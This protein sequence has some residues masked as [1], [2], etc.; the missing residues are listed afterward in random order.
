MTSSN[1]S[2][3]LPEF[4]D[5]EDAAR[6][7][8]G[9]AFRTP[10]LE[11]PLLNEEAGRRI[12][13]KAECLQRT[14]SF[15]FRGAYNRISRMTAEERARGVIAYSSGNHAQGV[16]HAAQI[17][18]TKATIVMPKDAPEMKLAN[19]Q[20]YGAQVVTYDRFGEDREEI[21]GEIAQRTGAVL[22]RPY[23]D[24]YV[25]AGQGTCGLELSEQCLERGIQPDAVITC[26]GGGGLTAG[27]SLAVEA[28]LPGARLFTSEPEHYDDWRLSLEKGERVGITPDHVS[29]C[30]AIVTPMPGVM[31]FP[32]AGPRLAG[33]L[34]VTDSQVKCAMA[35][36]F[37]RLKIIIEPGGA[38]AL[39]AA[40]YAGLADDVK[41]VVVTA[42]GGNVDQAVFA[43][44]LADAMAL[45]APRA[46]Q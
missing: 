19:T 1:P 21:G 46:A 5:V 36:A 13:V 37:D 9:E 23:D 45:S 43:A 25:I 39:A 15:K 10:L 42:S 16:A 34:V 32:I 8:G 18:G 28:K 29:I 33:G 38:V 17:C 27:I 26:C 20:A 2:G 30:D 14:G 35:R 31:T 40:L 11:S 24:F 7:I 6:Q 4:A 41:T 22:V 12:L 3:D 44:A